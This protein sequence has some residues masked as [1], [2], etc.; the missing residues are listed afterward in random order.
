MADSEERSAPEAKNRTSSL[1]NTAKLYVN[2]Q[3]PRVENFDLYNIITT[4]DSGRHLSKF[5]QL[6][7]LNELCQTQ[8]LPQHLSLMLRPT[9]SRVSRP[10]CLGM[11][12]PSGAYDQIIITVRQLRICWCGAR[13]LSL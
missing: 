7:M 11:K 12:H 1:I 4:C 10:V 9:V 2:L 3:V 8:C 6:Y 13:A 5:Y